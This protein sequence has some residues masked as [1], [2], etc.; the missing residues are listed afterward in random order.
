MSL[1]IPRA[2][3]PMSVQDNANY[4]HKPNPG[5]AMLFLSTSFSTLDRINNNIIAITNGGEW[6]EWTGFNG[7]QL[8]RKRGM[9]SV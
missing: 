7:G 5:H 8:N 2:G 9:L 1:N 4:R 3:V 6:M